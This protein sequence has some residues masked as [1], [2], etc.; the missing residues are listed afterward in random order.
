MTGLWNDA[1]F[2]MRGLFRTPGFTVITVGT[3][4]LGIGAVAAIFNVVNGVLLEPL[5]FD[6]PDA[7]VGVWHTAPAADIDEVGLATAMCL[8]YRAEN[9]FFEDIGFWDT[10]QVAV[11]GRA[12]PEQV[13][14]ARVTAGLLPVLRVQPVIGRR[15][16]EEDDAHGAPQTIMLSHGYWQRQF[17]ADP[18]TVGRTLRVDGI[19]REIIGVLPP[20]FVLPGREASIY[21]PLQ[22]DH[23]NLGAAWSHRAVARLAPGAT[24]EQ[25]SADLVRMLPTVPERFPAARFSLEIIE[26]TQLGPDLRPLKQDF[27]GDIGNVLWVLLGTVGIVLLIACA[28]VSNLFLV[29]AEGR[30]QEVAVRTALGAGR[31]QIARQFLA[32]SLVLGLVGGL[33]GLGI[34]LGGVRLLIWMGPASVPR[35][36]EISLAPPVLAFTLGIS[37]LSGLLS[38]LLPIVRIGGLDLVASLKEGGRGGSDGTERHRA[39]SALVVAQMALALVLFAGSGL[40]IRSFQELRNVNP[41]FANPEEVLTFRVAIPAAEI[42]ADAAVVLAYEDIW[43]RLREIPGVTS[44]GASTAV[45]MGGGAGFGTVLLVEDFPLRPDEALSADLF[46]WVTGDYFATMQNPVLVGRA[47]EWSDIHGG[48]PVALVTANLAEEY[49]GDPGAA[50]GKRIRSSAGNTGWR[51]IVGVV[52]NV[53]DSGVVQDPT[54]MIYF[55]LDT[56]NRSMAFAVRTTR[57]AA[58]SLL[59]EARAAVAA[60]NPNLPLANVRTLDEILAQSMARTSFTLVMLSIAAVVALALGVVGIYGVISYIV[61]HRTREI[62]VRMALGASHRD[63]SRMVLRQGMILAVIGVVVGLVVAVGL[64]RL[65]SALLYGVEATDPVTFGVVAAMLVA[66]ALVASYLPAIRASRTD[67]LAALRFE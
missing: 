28:N 36:D 12:E 14:V 66:V 53:H 35:L 55:P 31:G 26:R 37:M 40:M 49:W 22:W 13:A 16:T 20:A 50:I 46:K 4:A 42:E 58:A 3:L 27:V 54:P 63:V 67:P 10:R 11:T 8:T 7:L 48:P 65:M 34:A 38:G 2:V 30:L 47:I 19:P 6:D 43:R 61:S 57:R 60:V 44:V 9:R 5:P 23:A 59:P 21:I 17:A 52:G 1:R 62:G 45:T 41:G 32:E 15:F 25:A 64:T 51:E 24:I 33:G 39:R 18:T 56:T 29:R